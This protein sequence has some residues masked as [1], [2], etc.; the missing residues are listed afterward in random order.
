MENMD[1]SISQDSYSKECWKQTC[2][3]EVAGNER[4]VEEW[5]KNQQNFIL[6][7]DGASKNNPKRAGARGVVLNQQSE[8]ISTFVWGLETL[9]N[10]RAEAYGLLMGTSLLAKLQAKNP[11]IIGDSVIIITEMD[12]GREFT[13]QALN[14]IKHRINDNVNLL[15]KAVYKHVLRIHKQTTYA[16]ANKVVDREVGT[17]KENNDVSENPIP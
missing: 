6:L 2:K 5:I 10:N 15:G 13:N 3:L 11:I 16:L 9:S 14:K 12:S 1:E 8:T 7:F 17:T 4:E